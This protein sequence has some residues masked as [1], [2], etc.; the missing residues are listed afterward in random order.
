MLDIQFLRPYNMLGD[1]VG[2]IGGGVGAIMT[3]M[4]ILLMIKNHDSS[5]ARGD[6]T[7]RYRY[8]RYRYRYQYRWYATRL[9]SRLPYCYR[10]AL[11]SVERYKLPRY[12]DLA[13]VFFR[14]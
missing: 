4:R 14:G 9:A 7:T 10:A 5:G 12:R 2:V 1:V 8:Y 3:V 11:K 13:P 6:G